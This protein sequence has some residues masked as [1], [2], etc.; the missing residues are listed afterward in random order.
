M[1][2]GHREHHDPEGDRH[3]V[4]T[5]SWRMAPPGLATRRQLAAAGLRPNGQPVAAQVC[6]TSSRHA[7]T[8]RT[9]F[10]LLYRLDLAAARREPTV[11][12]LVA[13]AKADAARRTCPTCGRLTPYV[14]PTS[15]GQCLDCADPEPATPEHADASPS[16]ARDGSTGADRQETAA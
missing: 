12:Q 2:R 15:L 11:A 4:P 7:T 1:G 9:R 8:A 10:A 5:F 16:A 6:W 14:I 13:L 3:A